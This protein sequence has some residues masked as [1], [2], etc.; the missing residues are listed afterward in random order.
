MEVFY[1]R[2]WVRNSRRAGQVVHADKVSC[3]GVTYRNG[4]RQYECGVNNGSVTAAIPVF[5]ADIG[6]YAADREAGRQVDY[7][8]NLGIDIITQGNAVEILV[9]HDAILCEIAGNNRELRVFAT[10]V[11]RNIMAVYRGGTEN[12]VLVVC[13]FSQLVDCRI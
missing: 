4:R 10:A 5:T 3:F 12:E 8:R 9:L 1:I 2:N 7:F 6:K 11:Y 13:P